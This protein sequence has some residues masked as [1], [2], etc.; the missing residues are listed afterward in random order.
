MAQSDWQAGTEFILKIGGVAYP[1]ATVDLNLEAKEVPR[2]QSKHSPGYEVTKAGI[3]SLRA[4]LAGPY[5][6]GEVGI[7][8]GGEY[9]FSYTPA[10]ALTAF[11]FSAVVL[12]INHSNDV[13][14]GPKMAI[15]IKAQSDF[16]PTIG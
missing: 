11:E 4:D 6:S 3:K 16:T 5:R 7:T 2:N 14:D 10:A 8:L 9:T 12:K 13:E 15:S 1:F